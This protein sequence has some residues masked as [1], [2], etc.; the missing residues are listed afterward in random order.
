MPF[1][2]LPR[3]ILFVLIIAAPL[4]APAQKKKDE[5]KEAAI[6]KDEAD[7]LRKEIWGWNK[8]EFNVRTI[9]AEFA[10]ASKVI[11]ARHQEINADSKQKY[12]LMMY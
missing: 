1:Y 8:P 10:N 11:I 7:G 3:F 9:P 2:L 12:K 5:K 6:Y 4:I